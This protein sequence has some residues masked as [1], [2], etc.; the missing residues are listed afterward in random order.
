MKRISLVAALFVALFFCCS[1]I[2]FAQSAIVGT[3]TKDANLRAGPG[4]NY[5]IAGTVKAGQAVTIVGKNDAGTWYHLDNG[6]WIAAFLINTANNAPPATP[7]KPGNA[8]AKQ[9]PVPTP[10]PT[11]TPVSS[12]VVA[13]GKELHGLGWRFHVKEIHKRKA[14]YWDSRSH[15][16]MGHY[17]VVII[18]AV[19]EQSGTDYFD[20]NV[21]PYLVD[22]AQHVYFEDGDGTLYA[23]WQYSGISTVYTSVNPGNL[24]RIAMAFDL[25]DNLG[26]TML[27]TELPGWVDLGDFAK[28]KSE[29]N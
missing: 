5:A 24:V 4:T 10:A 16:A 17:L 11:A 18:D 23:T 20:R 14:V 9:T 21:K 19:N 25:P 27:S 8:P 22:D 7:T 15:V 28:M 3:V 6:K 12:S 1:L 2:I 13:I 26:H 29:D